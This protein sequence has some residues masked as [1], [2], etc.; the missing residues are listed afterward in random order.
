M[1]SPH[2]QQFINFRLNAKEMLAEHTP[3]LCLYIFAITLGALRLLHGTI[4]RG[5]VIP[6]MGWC[7]ECCL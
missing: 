6:L 7:L 2:L 4:F 1:D 3:L 5:V